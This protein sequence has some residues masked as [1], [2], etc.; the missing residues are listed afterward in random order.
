M[1]YPHVRR[2]RM[3]E[4]PETTVRSAA[5]DHRGYVSSDDVA[6][7]RWC[8][9][10]ICGVDFR[11]RVSTRSKPASRTADRPVAGPVPTETKSDAIAP[12]RSTAPKPV[13]QHVVPR[14]QPSSSVDNRVPSRPSQGHR[15]FPS[16]HRHHQHRV[17]RRPEPET[18]S[19]SHYFRRHQHRAR[20]HSRAMR[21]VAEW[22]E[23]AAGMVE[24]GDAEQGHQIVAPRHRHRRRSHARRHVHEHHHHHYHYSVSGVV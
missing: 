12:C 16:D 14:F 6:I 8:G 24:P 7:R 15:D 20:N 9:C 3:E 22:I 18:V 4:Q 5:D 10:L 17:G 1:T 19:S 21:Q 2:C 11:R 13:G 23:N